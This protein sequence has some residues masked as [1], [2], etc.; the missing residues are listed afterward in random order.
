MSQVTSLGPRTPHQPGKLQNVSKNED[1]FTRTI[2][3]VNEKQRRISAFKFNWV[4][5]L[6]KEVTRNGAVTKNMSSPA[7]QQR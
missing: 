5:S 2:S 7:R 4:Q 6:H 1:I 3:Y